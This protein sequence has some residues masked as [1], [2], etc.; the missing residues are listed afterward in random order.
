MSGNGIHAVKSEVGLCIRVFAC[1]FLK[2]L[3]YFYFKTF[4]F[5]FYVLFACAH[6]PAH[7]CANRMNQVRIRELRVLRN[8]EFL[9]T[10]GRK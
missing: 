4:L 5:C 1:G 6:A 9:E 3:L 10:K 2:T 8:L 7:P